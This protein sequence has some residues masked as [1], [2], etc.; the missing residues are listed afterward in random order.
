LEKRAKHVLPGSKWGGEEREGVGGRGRNDP[1]NVCMC[2][3]MNKEKKKELHDLV[4]AYHHFHKPFASWLS[5]S[6]FNV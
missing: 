2:G 3:Y 6:P 4:P 1:N 5:Q